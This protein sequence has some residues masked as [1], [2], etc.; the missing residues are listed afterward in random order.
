MHAQMVVA[1]NGLLELLP[2]KGAKPMT[3]IRVGAQT[4]RLMQTLWAK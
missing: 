4:M 1:S 3:T 2:K